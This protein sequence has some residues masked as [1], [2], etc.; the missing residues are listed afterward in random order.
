[1]PSPFLLPADGLW[2]RVQRVMK[3]DGYALAGRPRCC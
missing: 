1:M 3:A 2:V